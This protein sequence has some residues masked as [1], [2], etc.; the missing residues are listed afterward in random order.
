M[1]VIHFDSKLSL[2]LNNQV[3]LFF[4][5]WKQIQNQIIK[6]RFPSDEFGNGLSLCVCVCWMIQLSNLACILGFHCISPFNF[7][8]EMLC[9]VFFKNQPSTEVIAPDE[10]YIANVWQWLNHSITAFKK[11]S[12]EVYRKGEKKMPEII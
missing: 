9:L 11:W 10:R 2:L 7:Q 12:S 8:P 1:H 6:S 4:K 5:Y 3:H